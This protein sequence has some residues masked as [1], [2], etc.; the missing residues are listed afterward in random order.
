M[1]KGQGQQIMTKY[2]M[3]VDVGLVAD[4]AVLMVGHLDQEDRVVVDKV[5][6]LKAG[7]GDYVAKASL[8]VEE[9]TDEI[10]KLCDEFMVVHGV[11]DSWMSVLLFQSLRS[12]GMSQFRYVFKNKIFRDSLEMLLSKESFDS[13]VKTPDLLGAL[14]NLVWLIRNV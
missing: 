13:S 12:K 6:K 10:G 2:Y 11:F 4:S 14:E 9:I 5:S 3:G 7:E 1:G 8:H